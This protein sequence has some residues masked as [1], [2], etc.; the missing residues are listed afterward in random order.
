MITE[1][2]VY[3]QEPVIGV[4]DDSTLFYRCWDDECVIYDQVSGDTHL[5]DKASADIILT[6]LAQ[7]IPRSELLAKLS[8]SFTQWTDPEIEQFFDEFLSKCQQLHL[9]EV[10]EG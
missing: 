1:K 4:P 2:P 6:V 7:P 10:R 3:R 8:K 9:L 5:F